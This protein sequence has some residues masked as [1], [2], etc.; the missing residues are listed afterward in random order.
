MRV[1]LQCQPALIPLLSRCAG[2]DEI[3]P[4][5]SPPP[6]FDVYAALMS[7]PTLLGTTLETVPA[8]IPYL[9]ADPGLVEHWRR[10][11]AVVDGFKVGIA[12]QGSTTHA[13]DRHRSVP[14]TAFEPLAAVPGVR[15]ISLQK[16]PASQQIA[17]VAGRFAVAD[18]SDLVDRTAGAF[19]DT[20]AILNGLDL[21]ICVDTA[22]GH[23]AGGMGVPVWL[24]LHHTPDWRW[25]RGRE[26]S[27]WYP[28]ARLFRQPAPGEWGP[29]FARIAQELRELASRPAKKQRLMVEV[30][31]GELLDKLSILRIKSQ[32]I[33]DPAKQ[34]NVAI[35]KDVLISV[36]QSL[37]AS[38]EL[39][40]LEEQLTRVNEQLW[41][42][43]DAIRACER[44]ADFGKRFIALA[45]SV[46]HNN[47]RRSATEASD[48]R[49]VG[50]GDR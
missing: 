14:L 23:L 17:A 40:Q 16:G 36:R 22:I 9:H 49:V 20:A 13:W 34:R 31:A 18:F 27:P 2:I 29:V 6:T 28:S 25:L 4:W 7:L 39:E 12:W 37:P 3:V 33:T 24:A 38:R 46:Y 44:Q 42:I 35:E 15:L 21:V 8:D 5:G 10:Q 45:R 48:Q 50:L 32:R 47:D 30:S 26:D 43:E 19:M 11:L 1:I 41:D